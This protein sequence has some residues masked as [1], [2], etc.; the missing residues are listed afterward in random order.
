[1][2]MGA[3]ST[4]PKEKNLP[5][6]RSPGGTIALHAPPVPSDPIRIPAGRD[7]EVLFL[8]WQRA[9]RGDI[10]FPL[11]TILRAGHPLYRSTVSENTLRANHFRIPRTPSPYSGGAPSP[12]HNLGTELVNPWT[13]RE[14]IDAAGLDYTVMKKPLKEFIDLGHTD[15]M[16]DCSVTVRTDT[17]DILGVVEDAY[18]PVQNRDAFSF[19]DNLVATEEATYET[20]GI[21]GRGER[22]WILARLPGFINVHG[23]DI[24]SKYLLLSNSHDGNSRI[25][26]K[27]TPIRVVCNNTLTAALEGAGE[28]HIR[29][30]SNAAENMVQALSLLGLTNRLYEQ[31]DACFNRMALTKISGKHLTDYVNELIPDNGS[32]GDEQRIGRIRKKFMDLYETGQGA[33]L[34][35]GTLWG[36]FNCVTEYTDHVMEGNPAARLESIWFG[37]GDKLKLRAFQLAERLMGTIH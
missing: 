22:A 21:I 10:C 1:M 4:K 24:V 19:F 26:V 8:G 31:L 28:V 33:D 3:V 34:S 25:R 36:A 6:M 35:R 13:A 2:G 5:R 11:Y 37:G 17:G 30:T 14:A 20:A 29:H 32:N 23:K 7:E 16:P 9:L 27:I 12:W 18:E 15:E